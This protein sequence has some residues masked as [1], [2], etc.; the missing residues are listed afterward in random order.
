MSQGLCLFDANDRLMV[1]NRRYAQ[2][3]GLPV[4]AV[5]PG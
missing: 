4:G 2:I 5:A 1:V 3:Y